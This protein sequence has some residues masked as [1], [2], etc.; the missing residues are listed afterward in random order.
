M[1]SAVAIRRQPLFC[2]HREAQGMSTTS[3][4]FRVSVAVFGELAQ[5]EKLAAE[6]YDPDA[7][8][9]IELVIQ[10]G[11]FAGLKP[12]VPTLFI[13]SADPLPCLVETTEP[14]GGGQ[15][16]STGGC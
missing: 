11:L 6:L 13:V 7:R 14:L 5:L 3:L 4:R 15:D 16:E 10:D 8:R 9:F 2:G 1:S 12:R